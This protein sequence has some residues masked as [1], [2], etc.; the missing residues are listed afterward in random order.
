MIIHR[1]SGILAHITSLPSPYGIGDIGYA[2]Y[3]FIDFLVKGGQS[4]WQFLPVS[5]TDKFLDHSPY[6][7][8]SAFAGNSL[9]LSPELL[10]E[11]DLISRTTRDAHP[12][13]SPYYT[14]FE[15]VETYKK[16]ILSEAYSNFSPDH[17]SAYHEFITTQEWLEDYASFMTLKKVYQKL[18]WYEWPE[19][20]ARYDRE[21]ISEICRQEQETF[22]YFQF[23]QF[24]FN[25]Q[26]L[27]LKKY[28]GQNQIQLFGDLPI[29][30]SLD[31]VDV[32]SNQEIFLLDNDSLQPSAV[33]GVPPDYFSKTGQRW[34]NPL[35]DWQNQSSE[36]RHKLFRW[37]QYRLEHLFSLMDIVRIDH[38][39][40]FAAYWSVPAAEETAI[41]GK[42]IPGPG[43]EL[44]DEISR[45]LGPLPI[46]AEDLG[47]ITE[48]VEQLRD[49]LGYP[50]MKILQFAFD[51]NQNNPYLPWNFTSPNCIVYTGTHDNDT[52]VGWFLSDMLTDAQRKEIQAI[53]NRDSSTLGGIHEDLM[54]LALASTSCLCIFP[55]QDLFGFGSDCRMNRPG[56][57]SGNWGW[58]CAPQYL[59]AEISSRLSIATNLFGRGRT[60]PA[61]TG[62]VSLNEPTKSS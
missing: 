32:W 6:M 20:I 21:Q 16:A 38:F 37:W 24:L 9:L 3:N 15:K 36:I 17:D 4:Y 39:R 51:G 55:L 42:W 34:G 33:A 45:N 58:R 54:Y 44:F 59:S 61:T 22:R 25:Q 62:S 56:I 50:G 60:P 41:N 28:A 52:T 7:S 2:S 12:D 1:S 10:F 23:E 11:K 18:P 57:G 49:D 53:C 35:Y 31:S 47:I 26:W 43:K 19:R 14:E 40:G 5:P 27:A 48:E 46:V 13:F 30:V 8:Y 29:Y